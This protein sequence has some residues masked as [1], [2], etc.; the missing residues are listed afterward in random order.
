MNSLTPI[1]VTEL[2]K[3]LGHTEYGIIVNNADDFY[4]SGKVFDFKRSIITLDYE[5]L[6]EKSYD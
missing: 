3:N 1:H 4:D 2:K 5:D 6:I